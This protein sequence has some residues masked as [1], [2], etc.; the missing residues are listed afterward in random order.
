MQ[1]ASRYQVQVQ[2]S[3]RFL[4]DQSLPAEGRY[5]FAYTIHIRNTGQVGARLI[6]RHWEIRHGNGRVE[7]VDGDGV[8]GEQPWLR[9]GEDFRY[10]SAVLLDTDEGSMQGSYDLLA[11]DGTTFSAPITPFLLNTPR[12][13]H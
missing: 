6:A 5:A 8:V 7:Y 13:L 3:P 4:D 12:T 9:P 1:D 10:T 2:V 11:D